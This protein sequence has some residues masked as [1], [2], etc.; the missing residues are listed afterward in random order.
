MSYKVFTGPPGAEKVSPIEKD[1]SL[2]KEVDD[3]D[4]ALSF[5]HHVQKNGTVPL[6]I[7]GDDGTRLDKKQ[8]ATALQHRGSE[9]ASKSKKRKRKRKGEWPIGKK[10]LLFAP[11]HSPFAIPPG[12]APMNE[13]ALNTSVRKFPKKV[14]VTSQREIEK[15]V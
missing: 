1:R 10:C 8:I 5:A 2:F 3:L 12:E 15:A 9:G 13:D 11:R 14:G 4:Q 6:L 7:E